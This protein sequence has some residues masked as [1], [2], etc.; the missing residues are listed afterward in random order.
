M[1]CLKAARAFTGRPKIAKVEGCYHGIYD[2]AEVSQTAKPGNWGD[3]ENP[4]SVPVAHGTP[5]SVLD[6][7]VV[8]P[9]ND[10]ERAVTILDRHADELACVLVDPLPHRVCLHP[11]SQVF[12]EALRR[13]TLENDALLAFDEV[14][15][16]RC[17]YGGAQEWYDVQPDLTAMG[18]VIGG[19][20]PVGAIAG[21]G[22]VMNVLDPFAEKVLFPHSGTFSANPITMTGGLTAM[23]LYDRETIARVNSLADRARQEITA[24]IKAAD[25]PACVTGA[26]SIFRIHMKPEPPR[27]HR[28]S[29]LNP[30]ES[31]LLKAL[32]DYFFAHG[33]ML[34][35]TCSG[36]ISTPMTG[37]EI[38]ALAEVAQGGFQRV[39]EMRMELTAVGQAG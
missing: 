25:V 10:P 33:I 5:S 11:A 35:N 39:K 15:T 12:V 30:D 34:I 31:R 37:R 18:K 3:P 38:D 4:V 21:R 2:F 19:G 13:W 7:V 14:I 17:E 24:A 36:T 28:S 29:F 22:A 23:R 32:L 16:Y 1:C 6:D 20:F 8:I 27:D 26:G 9:F